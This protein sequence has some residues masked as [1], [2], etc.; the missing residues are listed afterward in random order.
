MKHI[1][2]R[3]SAVRPSASMAASL[4]AKALMAK[5]VD[6]IDLSL[7]EPDF[8][9]PPHIVDA[10]YEAAKRGDTLYTAPAG[11]P[12]LREA[13][14]HKFE[15]DNALTFGLDQIAVA[16]GGKQ[17]I[18]N[19]LMAT[20]DEGDEVILSAPYFV[21]YPEMVRLVG[22][23]PVSVPCPAESGFLLTPEALQAAITPRTKWLIL[24]SPNN[25]SGAVYSA[26]ELA[27]L[28]AVLE[29][30][31]QVLILSDEIYEHILFD[32]RRFTSFGQACPRLSD[33]S[34][35]MNGMSK[36]YSMTGWRVGYAAG[37]AWLIAAMCTIQ[38]Q[39]CTSVCSIA[40]AASVAALN[41]SQDHVRDFRAA[42]ER[43][44]D[45]VVQR[46]GDIPA[47]T[48]S[49][50][51][52]AFYGFI[53]CARLIGAR[54][55][56]GTTLTDDSAIAHYLLEEGHVSAVPG[57]AYGLSP[58]VRISTATSETVLTEAVS[59]IATAVGRLQLRNAA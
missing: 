6:V 27:A 18:F 17:V 55:A 1:A 39:S 28:G 50:P 29:R 49:P 57:A 3:L 54:T 31:P 10:A 23:V 20:I 56:S 36:T 32:G 37:P 16:N 25:P 48:L 24:N 51:S 35:I 13:I 34:L 38:S 19:A 52:G 12:A 45:L 33:R 7:G 46:I 11:T 8:P 22:G 58:F 42:F 53:G 5:G 44:R 41:G 26:A 21:S 9:T 2:S 43:R 15:R 30:H 47:L 14:A 40:Q 59:R 4:A